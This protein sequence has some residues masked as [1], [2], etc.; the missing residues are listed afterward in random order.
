MYHSGD[1]TTSFIVI[2]AVTFIIPI[3][4]M[5]FDEDDCD[6]CMDWAPKSM[7]LIHK[8]QLN[9]S[10][11]LPILLSHL[12]ICWPQRYHLSCHRHCNLSCPEQLM[13]AQL[14]MQ[15]PRLY[16]LPPWYYSGAAAIDDD[17]EVTGALDV[18][19]ERHQNN[20]TPVRLNIYHSFILHWPY[21]SC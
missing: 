4:V 16:R 20:L 5:Y 2:V 14:P 15:H 21:H 8:H 1:D 13:A 12:L 10:C 18:I 6:W 9:Q 3:Q 7:Q 17:Q 11:Q 19:R